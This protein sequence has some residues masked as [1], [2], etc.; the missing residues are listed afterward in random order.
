M[1]VGK[2]VTVEYVKESGEETIRCIIPMDAPKDY[3][4][5]IDMTFEDQ[6]KCEEL[7][8]A[9]KEYKEYK[10]IQIKKLYT[11]EDWLTHTGRDFEKLKW[12][13]FKINNILDESETIFE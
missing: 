6:D 12:R 8:K 2:L 7:A 11:F 3:I 9:I 1:E 13:T 4:R 10:E 5:A